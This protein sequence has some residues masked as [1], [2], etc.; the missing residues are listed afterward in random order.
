MRHFYTKLALCV[1]AAVAALP[2]GAAANP[3]TSGYGINFDPSTDAKTD[4]KLFDFTVAC[5]TNTKKFTMSSTQTNKLYKDLCDASNKATIE[6]N[7]NIT[8]SINNRTYAT[9]ATNGSTAVWIHYYLYID[10][11]SNGTFD[12]VKNGTTVDKDNATNELLSWSYYEGTNSAGQ[13]VQAGAAQTGIPVFQIP[14]ERL[15]PGQTYHARLKADYN[16]TDPAGGAGKSK[17]NLVDLSG[18]IADFLVVVPADGDPEDPM[19]F[20]IVCNV[21]TTRP[22][23]DKGNRWVNS[24]TVTA[25]PAGSTTATGSKQYSNTA[26][27][28]IYHNLTQSGMLEA[29]AGDIITTAIDH[30]NGTWVHSYMYVDLDK[31]DALRANVSDTGEP[32]EGNEL[33]AWSYYKG[34]EGTNDAHTAGIANNRGV[35]HLPAFTLPATLKSGI[36]H[37]RLKTDWD[38]T[39]PEG[40]DAYTDDKGEA[41]GIVANGGDI[42]DFLIHVTNEAAGSDLMLYAE[43][44]AA[45]TPYWGTYYSQDAWQVA[46]GLTACV[47][48]A[49][50]ADGTLTI[51]E[52]YAAGSYVPRHTP[53][54]VKG[55]GAHAH[56]AVHYTTEHLGYHPAANLLKGWADL[57]AQG[58]TTGGGDGEYLYYTLS[59]SLVDGTVGDLGFFWHEAD[60]GAFAFP[61]AS[62]DRAYLAVPVQQAR[63][64]KRLSFGHGDTTGISVAP[65][66]AADQAPQ[67]IYSITGTY[68]G[69]DRQA[70]PA[71][72]YVVGGK[73]MIVK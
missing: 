69:T 21:N 20:P 23:S 15:T 42:F 45:D 63:G 70:L 30:T 39:D 57:N 4:R 66:E 36:Y 1:L 35:N 29:K 51:D 2:V 67:R 5:G 34:T 17:D 7:T 24:F 13:T 44:S 60:G 11:N 9:T 19:V 65:V 27:T 68:V 73:K 12:V 50:A 54:L 37:A 8:V 25:K 64:I 53:V 41:Q 32:G 47:I 71:G 33:V 14:A 49:V 6:A 18:F 48:T 62:S 38:S 28:K 52:K 56:P 46:E 58:M 55:D 3:T 40:V 22:T 72:I 16:D 43:T 61:A 26:T 10:L 59:H 31:D